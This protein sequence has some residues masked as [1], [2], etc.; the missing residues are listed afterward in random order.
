MMLLGINDVLTKF[1]FYYS[2]INSPT[3]ES[4][5]YQGSLFQFYYSSINSIRLMYI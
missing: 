2:S 1:Q 3:D 5:T 4:G